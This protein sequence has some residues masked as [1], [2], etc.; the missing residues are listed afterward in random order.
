MTKNFPPLDEGLL[1]N[2][3]LAIADCFQKTTP[4]A[5][6]DFGGTL[7]WDSAEESPQA[8][9]RKA[10][11]T[12]D[13]AFLSKLQSRIQ[14]QCVWHSAE[15]KVAALMAGYEKNESL[16]ADLFDHAKGAGDSAVD[17][18]FVSVVGREVTTVADVALYFT[19]KQFHDDLLRDFLQERL[20]VVLEEAIK[21]LGEEY[22]KVAMQNSLHWSARCLTLEKQGESWQIQLDTAA[23]ENKDL[24][25]CLQ[26]V[27]AQP[28]LTYHSVGH[29]LLGHACELVSIIM[30]HLL[31][32]S[33]GAARFKEA[34]AKRRCYWL[35]SVGI[36]KMERKVFTRLF[37]DNLIHA[38]AM[39]EGAWNGY[40]LRK[41]IAR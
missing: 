40:I 15:K 30:E 26:L 28:A 23:I 16:L 10:L 8:V 34:D 18:V 9:L 39:N 38:S 31:S 29:W 35:S 22:V 36:P 41:P 33:H 20:A 2:M 13:Q 27:P 1:F 24:F 32:E 7:V 6:S 14:A 4:F 17:H 5:Y 3:T 21:L 19:C 11:V 25:P 12:A 37:I